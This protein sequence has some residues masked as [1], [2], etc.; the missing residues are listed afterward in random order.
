MNITAIGSNRNTITS[1]TKDNNEIDILE[2]Q[3]M[4]LQ[5]QMKNLNDSKIDEST[6]KERRK[7]LED[8]IQQIDAQVQSMQSDRLKDNLNSSKEDS[9]KN[10]GVNQNSSTNT[11][12]ETDLV[13]L[14]SIYSKT[15]LIN[16]TKK[17]F[18]GKERVLKA[19]IKIDA[20]R[21]AATERKEAE[22]NEIE[23]K[24]KDLY[25]KLG[26]EHKEVNNKDKNKNSSVNINEEKDVDYKKIDTVV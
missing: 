8:Q 23:K 18:N 25:K 15:Q 6:K 22:L 16:K 14:N 13:Q 12:N 9:N 21:G 11:Y 24:D 7:M 20:G 1:Y 5:E 4:K 26:K 3:K 19:E 2:K 10:T 17:D